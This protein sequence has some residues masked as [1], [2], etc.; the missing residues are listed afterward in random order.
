MVL[1]GPGSP[2]QAGND[3]V[4][5]ATAKRLLRTVAAAVPGIA[6]LSGG[7][8]SELVAAR[9]IQRRVGA[10]MIQGA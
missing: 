5:G 4:A 3:A 10:R 8:S 1:T 7:Q 9:R 2:V 6:S